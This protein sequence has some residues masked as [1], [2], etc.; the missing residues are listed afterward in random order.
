MNQK[1]VVITYE[2]LYEILR[3]EK[4][5]PE[6]QKLDAQFLQDCAEYIKSKRE[7]FEKSLRDPSLFSSSEEKH[8]ELQLLNI[9]KII[10]EIYERREK[11]IIQ[12]A[13]DR[14]KSPTVVLDPSTLLQEEAEFLDTL[15]KLLSKHRE[16]FTTYAWDGKEKEKAVRKETTFVRFLQAVPKFVGQELEAYGPFQEEDMANLPTLIAELLIKKGR[17]EEIKEN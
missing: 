17:A 9:K 7:V 10:R 14:S 5:R 11:K 13:I 16:S 6:L 1:D 12:M 15:T 2:T 8:T 4:I 3:L